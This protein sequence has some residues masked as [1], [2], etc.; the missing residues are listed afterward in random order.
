MFLYFKGQDKI[1]KSDGGFFSPNYRILRWTQA[2]RVSE[3]L[4]RE[5]TRRKQDCYHSSV[6][7]ILNSFI[8]LDIHILN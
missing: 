8:H 5:I 4:M 7:S 1:T 3:A 6:S 2:V